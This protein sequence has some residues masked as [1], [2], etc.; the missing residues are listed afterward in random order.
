[1]ELELS[2]RPFVIEES[3]FTE[4]YLWW[5]KAP[6]LAEHFRSE[7]TK[8]WTPPLV[9]QTATSRQGSAGVTYDATLV[10]STAQGYS[11]LAAIA[12]RASRKPGILPIANAELDGKHGKNGEHGIDGRN[13]RNKQKGGPTVDSGRDGA[14]GDDGT[15]GTHG[16]NATSGRSASRVDVHL[17]GSL[18]A[19]EVRASSGIRSAMLAHISH[20]HVPHAQAPCP[21]PVPVPHV[22]ANQ[23]L[24]LSNHR[25]IT[26]ESTTFSW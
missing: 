23:P 12:A 4:G 13:G 14:S 25:R 8:A 24:R 16:E 5:V 20:A 9:R 11:T 3:A 22:H 17:S 26:D 10:Q 1:M 15:R 7:S 21:R 18:E 6:T 2:P 19:L